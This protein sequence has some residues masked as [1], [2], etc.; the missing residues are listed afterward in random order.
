[1][2]NGDKVFMGDVENKEV[3]DTEVFGTGVVE[4][5]DADAEAKEVSS[6]DNVVKAEDIHVTFSCGTFKLFKSSEEYDK[7][8]LEG[9]KSSRAIYGQVQE[10]ALV[11]HKEQY[12]EP[13]FLP[14]DIEHEVFAKACNKIM[15]LLKITRLPV[16]SE[17]Q[18]DVLVRK[19]LGF[20][21]NNCITSDS[22]S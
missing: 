13:V 8:V 3:V 1:M 2:G 4:V 12:T 10:G 6:E 18:Q 17:S 11:L 21:E 14:L 20:Y 16:F 22:L 5:G 9:A 19:F 15:D 7:Y